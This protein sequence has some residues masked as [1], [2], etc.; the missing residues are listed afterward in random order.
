MAPIL[1]LV[2]WNCGPNFRT[3]D[4]VEFA[5]APRVGQAVLACPRSYTSSG[6]NSVRA[7]RR[8]RLPHLRSSRHRKEWLSPF[9]PP[10]R[11]C[12]ARSGGLSLDPA[13]RSACA[14]KTGSSQIPRRQEFCRWLFGPSTSARSPKEPAKSRLQPRLAAPRIMR[15]SVSAKVSDI[16]LQPAP[17]S[18]LSLHHSVP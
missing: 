14:S 10:G 15:N 3:P 11:N 12:G 16:R 13:G 5:A 6:P 1:N 9:S 17:H 8:H 7:G 4:V 18:A 2:N